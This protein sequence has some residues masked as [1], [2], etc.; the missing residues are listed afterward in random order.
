MAFFATCAARFAL[1]TTIIVEPSLA[2]LG[3]FLASPSGHKY[4]AFWTAAFAIFVHSEAR[5]TLHTFTAGR[6]TCLAPFGAFEA[7]ISVVVIIVFSAN[8]A[9][10][11]LVSESIVAPTRLLVGQREGQCTLG[12]LGF[13]SAL[14][15]IFFARKTAQ[16][17]V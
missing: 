3:R 1:I 12:A 14:E 17:V 16:V 2:H 11:E 8:H 10:I 15:A 13:A 7:V 5:L 6:G 4:V 9:H